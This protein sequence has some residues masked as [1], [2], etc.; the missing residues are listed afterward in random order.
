MRRRQRISIPLSD[1]ISCYNVS[2]EVKCFI[3]FNEKLL[4]NGGNMKE[5]I[6]IE[7]L[8]ENE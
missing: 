1:L 8:Q 4:S 7:V 6:I 2:Q 3:Y 5:E